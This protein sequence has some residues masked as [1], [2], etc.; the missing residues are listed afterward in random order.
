MRFDRGC[1]LP[2]AQQSLNLEARWVVAK[3]NKR[4]RILTDLFYLFLRL[5]E[6]RLNW[7]LV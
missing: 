3:I 5:G 4:T 2:D 1:F 7:L 6:L